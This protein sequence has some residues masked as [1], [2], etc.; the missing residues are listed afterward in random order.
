MINTATEEIELAET[1]SVEVGQLA[2]ALSQN[3]P[4]YSFFRYEHMHDGQRQTPTI[5]IYT[6][7][8]A[9]KPKERMLYS[10]FKRNTISLAEGAGLTIDKKVSR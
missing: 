9:S 10:C 6:C 3:A 7:P 4:R 2:S 1:G 5:F 8:E